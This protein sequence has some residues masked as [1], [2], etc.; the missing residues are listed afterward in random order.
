MIVDLIVFLAVL[1]VLI[2]VHEF[3]HFLFARIFGVAVE[4]FGFGFPPRLGGI[5]RGKTLYSINAL[6]LGGFVKIAGEDAVPAAGGEMLPPGNFASKSAL[7]RSAILAAGVGFNLILA[8]FLFAMALGFGIPVSADDPRWAGRIS[9]A[10]VVAV[11]VS[12]ASAAEQSGI[13]IG[14]AIAILVADREEP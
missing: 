5:K 6:P 7:K 13:R 14:D 2:L 11:D 10:H 4:E 9:D 12:R 3:G 1:A 8:Y